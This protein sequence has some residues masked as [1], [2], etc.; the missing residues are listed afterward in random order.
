MIG[1][2]K[3]SLKDLYRPNKYLIQLLLLDKSMSD[4]FNQKI[5]SLFD[6]KFE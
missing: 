1:E 3:I 5:E 4:L 6:A 2:H